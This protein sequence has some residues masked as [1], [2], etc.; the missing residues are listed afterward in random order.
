MSLEPACRKAPDPEV[1][2]LIFPEQLKAAL[3]FCRACVRVDPCL[4]AGRRG[5]ETGVWGGQ[6]LLY[7]KPAER[8]LY[9]PRDE[10]ISRRRSA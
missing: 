8:L 6:L 9:P 1:F 3:D 7:G 5:R 10:R 4:T 2:H